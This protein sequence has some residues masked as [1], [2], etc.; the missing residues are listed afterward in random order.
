MNAASESFRPDHNIAAIAAAYCLDCIDVARSNFQM[1][2]DGTDASIELVEQMLGQLHDQ[3]QAAKPSAEQIGAFAKMFGSY[4]GEVYRLKH[5]AEWGIVRLGD[6][7]FPG[8]RSSADGLQFWPW[9]R[10]YNRITEGPE[11]NIWHYY[12]ALVERGNDGG[13]NASAT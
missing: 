8:M 3:L 6:S 2:L 12:V 13:D 7:E 10:A 4:L 9:E 5:G 11:N 1:E